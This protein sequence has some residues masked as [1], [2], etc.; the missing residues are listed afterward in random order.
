MGQAF[1]SIGWVVLVQ[2]LPWVWS[3]DVVQAYSHLKARL[4][5]ENL[6]LRLFPWEWL[7]LCASLWTAWVCSW[8]GSWPL[9]EQ[10]I[11]EKAQ[12]G[13]Y[14]V[15]HDLAW[16]LTHHHFTIS[17]WLYGSAL[18]LVGDSMQGCEQQEA[19]ITGASFRTWMKKM[20]A[21]RTLLSKGE[22]RLHI[23]NC[24]NNC[25]FATVVLCSDGIVQGLINVF[26][27][28]NL[29]WFAIW[30][31]ISLKKRHFYWHLVDE[32]ELAR[33]LAAEGTACMKALRQEHVQPFKGPEENWCMC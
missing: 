31:K 19:K 13:S 7:P 3:Q 16:E 18:F 29:I 11:W 12:N 26:N 24:R 20:Q 30:G 2:G 22:N 10:V 23:N 1:R 6:L 25:L 32:K 28:E 9:S 14:N 21:S 15:S 33:Y 8:H 17:H 27:M 5:L 4:G